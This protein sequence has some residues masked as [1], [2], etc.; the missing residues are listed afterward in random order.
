MPRWISALIAATTLGGCEVG[1]RVDNKQDVATMT[2][3]PTRPIASPEQM[4]KLREE[5][6]AANKPFMDHPEYAVTDPAIVDPCITD[7]LHRLGDRMPSAAERAD[8]IRDAEATLFNK[9]DE[10][11]GLDRIAKLIAERYAHPTIRRAGDVV[12]IDAGVVAGTLQ[13]FRGV[14]QID[15]SPNLA[16]GQWTTAEVVRF[17]ELGMARFPDAKTYVA[18]VQIPKRSA[19]P[20]WTYVFDRQDDRIWVYAEELG[21]NAYVS[22]KLGGAPGSVKSLSTFDLTRQDA[23]NPLPWR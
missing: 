13:V 21:R 7:A 22:G 3:T 9:L 8:V 6:L 5:V 11:E 18:H 16:N 12:K 4:A 2:T 15:Q 23:P 19:R 10:P 17:L 1:K 14:T 20:D